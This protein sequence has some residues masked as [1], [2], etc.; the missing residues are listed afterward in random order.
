MRVFA[1]CV[2]LGVSLSFGTAS[3]AAHPRSDGIGDAAPVW[4]RDGERIA[5]QRWHRV[6]R[7]SH[8]SILELGVGDGRT[9]VLRRLG[10]AL[11][12]AVSPDF[13][14]VAVQ[15]E[16]FL[17]LVDLRT[18]DR[19]RVAGSVLPDL[20][21]SSDGERLAFASSQGITVVGRDGST[22]IVARG[23]Q[24]SW[25]PDGSWLVYV[26]QL[27]EPARAVISVVRSD[28]RGTARHLGGWTL[29]R[30]SPN[31]RT[32]AW[33]DNGALVVGDPDGSTQRRYLHPTFTN[34]SAPAWSPDSRRVATTVENGHALVFE[35]ATGRKTYLTRRPVRALSWA[36]SGERLAAGLPDEACLRPGIGVVR[37]GG[38]APRK[39]TLDCRI[40]GTGRDDVLR[41]SN[42]RDILLGGRGDDRLFGRG[43]D[44][45]FEP[46]PGR[47]N[48]S[49]GR[50]V[51]AVYADAPDRIAADCERVAR[52]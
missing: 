2:C 47:D 28:G 25:S 26:E 16:D 10:P 3:D 42:L 27:S 30:W 23:T 13:S 49:C 31:G 37:V 9:K 1:A 29:P 33:I 40:R 20:A 6:G 51:D 46:G 21:W 17:E 48:V 45:R 38:G 24:P 15:R 14:A 7:A 35:L 12:A 39:L 18:N 36:P 11:W 43:G 41:G 52:R 34:F 5:F 22:R 50:G 32:I 19:R 44:D 4:S 8:L